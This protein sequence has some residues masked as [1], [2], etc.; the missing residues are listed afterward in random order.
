MNIIPV[1]DIVK[2]YTSID[3]TT[4]NL[5]LSLFWLSRVLF[6]ASLAAHMKY[7]KKHSRIDGL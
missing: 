5:F 7:A 3:S 6:R 1:D 2:Q 4:T